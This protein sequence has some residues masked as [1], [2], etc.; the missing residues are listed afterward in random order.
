MH[1]LDLAILK[2]KELAF[3]L[4]FLKFLTSPEDGCL[5]TLKSY[6][7]LTYF[8]SVQDGR[9]CCDAQAEVRGQFVDAGSLL[10]PRGFQGL[11]SG[12]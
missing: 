4:C 2:K 5:V 9:V 6:S 1:F 8:F 3:K 10:L 12:H 11:N 7:F